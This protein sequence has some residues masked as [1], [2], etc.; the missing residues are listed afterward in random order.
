MLSANSIATT[1]SASSC[2]VQLVC[3][4]GSARDGDDRGLSL[5]HLVEPIWQLEKLFGQQLAAHRR[6]YLFV[7]RQYLYE[8]ICRVV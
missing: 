5:E 6:A 4:S 1:L 7:T 3:P 2:S 8:V